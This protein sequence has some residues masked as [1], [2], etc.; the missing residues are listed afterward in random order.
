M[1][2]PKSGHAT[3]LALAQTPRK[4]PSARVRQAL[5]TSSSTRSAYS[6]ATP[7]QAQ[8]WYRF[9]ICLGDQ[10][11]PFVV[12]RV[13]PV[14]AAAGKLGN[15]VVAVLEIVDEAVHSELHAAGAGLD[16]DHRSGCGRRER[17]ARHTRGSGGRFATFELE[18][19][20]ALR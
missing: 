19:M 18:Q 17:G 3:R 8:T 2:Q 14:P 20:Q 12:V 9:R 13:R 15:A 6:R 10:A 11:R 16:L 1:L 4:R 7:S 5:A